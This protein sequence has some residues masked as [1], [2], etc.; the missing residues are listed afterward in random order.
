MPYLNQTHVHGIVLIPA[1]T[2]TPLNVQ[3]EYLSQGQ[4]VTKWHLFPPIA[5]AAVHLWCKPELDLVVS[6]HTNQCLC[7]NTFESPLPLVAM[8]LDAFNSPWLIQVSLFVFSFSFSSPGP[9]QVPST[10]CYY[11]IETSYSS[12]TLLDGGSLA[13]HRSQHASRH[14]TSVSHCKIPDVYVDVVQ[15][16]KVLQLLH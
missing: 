7:C 8:R 15:V 5:Q 12:D 4:S 6:S 16:L 13:P 3:A 9:F 2:H 14:F 10:M 11:L 1:Y